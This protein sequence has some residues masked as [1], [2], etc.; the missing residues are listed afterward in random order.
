MKVSFTISAPEPTI[1]CGIRTGV[2]GA[3]SRSWCDAVVACVRGPRPDRLT[4]ALE[5]PPVGYSR[6]HRPELVTDDEY[7]RRLAGPQTSGLVSSDGLGWKASTYEVRELTENERQAIET[8]FYFDPPDGPEG[9]IARWRRLAAGGREHIID[10]QSWGLTEASLVVSV[11][12]GLNEANKA[13]YAAFT[14][15]Q[16]VNLALRLAG[17]T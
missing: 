1:I 8:V 16:M 15:S 9:R 7:T 4:T 12:D 6:E 10:G 5:V 14:A 13:R 17:L 11:Y 2:F 3:C